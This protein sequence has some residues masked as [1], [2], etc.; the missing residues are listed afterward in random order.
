LHEVDR[1]ADEHDPDD[2]RAADRIAQQSRN[3]AR[4]Q[5]DHD[6][7]IGEQEQELNEGPCALDRGRL[8]ITKLVQ[9]PSRFLSSQ[10]V[11]AVGSRWVSVDGRALKPIAKRLR[12]R[13][14]AGPSLDCDLILQRC[15]PS[16]RQRDGLGQLLVIIRRHLTL[17][18]DGAAAI[19]GDRDVTAPHLACRKQ[20]PMDVLSEL[21][22][23]PR[24][25]RQ[26]KPF[27]RTGSV[28]RL[29]TNVCH[30]GIINAG[31]NHKM[32]S[33]E[34]ASALRLLLQESPVNRHPMNFAIR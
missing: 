5:K 4:D 3:N 1:H 21:L 29:I 17:E 28:D 23:S 18:H 30:A 31:W 8:V 32:N 26:K 12:Y 2:D 15:D 24:I 34:R 11:L 16:N 9:Q 33:G 20:C 27:E 25:L 13:V 14:R 10:A 7:R 19:G 22:R 6:E